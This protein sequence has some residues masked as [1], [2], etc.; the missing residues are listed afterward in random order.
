MATTLTGATLTGSVLGT[1]TGIKSCTVGGLEVADIVYSA[2]DDAGAV[3]N[4]IPGT[5]TEG[6]MTFTVVYVAALQLAL[7]QA[8]QFLEL[9]LPRL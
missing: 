6:P 3:T 5:V 2:T 8:Q 7:R 9:P 1:I 4:H